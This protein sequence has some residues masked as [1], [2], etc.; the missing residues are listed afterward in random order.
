[1]L[2]ALP[3]VISLLALVQRVVMLL[4]VRMLEVMGGSCLA[5]QTQ[6]L[7]CKVQ[8]LLSCVQALG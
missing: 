5:F 3:L 6:M 4:G 2:A 7:R 8:D 1:M